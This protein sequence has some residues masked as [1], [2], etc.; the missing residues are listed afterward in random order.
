MSGQDCEFE[1]GWAIW[2]GRAGA[3]GRCRGG[4]GGAGVCEV[5]YGVRVAFESLGL[6]EVGCVS[7]TGG[8]GGV[9]TAS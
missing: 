1:Q 2:G 8:K 7:E 9:G 5:V 6:E 3:D 4:E